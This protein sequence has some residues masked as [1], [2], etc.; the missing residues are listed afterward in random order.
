MINSAIRL[1]RGHPGLAA[2]VG[3]G[4]VALVVVV[5]V[6]FARLP[7]AA[8]ES[9]SPAGSTSASP[10]DGSAA[11]SSDATVE[12][13]PVPTVRPSV[14]PDW[15]PTFPIRAAFYYPWFPE[16][17]A[18]QGLD[19][20][21]KYHPS[22]GFYD[23]AA[24]AVIDSHIDAMLY[25]KISAGIASWWGQGSDTDTRMPALLA[26]TGSLPFRWAV[27]YEPEG[28]GDP[29]VQQIRSDLAYLAAHYGSDPAYLKVDGRMVVF[30][31]ADPKDGCAMSDRW[32]AANTVH[33]YVVLK[34][35]AGYQDCRRQP[36]SWH[37]Y[38]AGTSDDPQVAY[39]YTISP[40]F[41]KASE[42]I[43]RL[44]RDLLRWTSSIKT[45]AGSGLP[46]Q[47]ITTFNEWGE[48][49]SIESAVEWQTGSGYGAYLDALHTDGAS[50]PQATPIP[51]L[52][53]IGVPAGSAVLVGA[54]DIAS[55]VSAGDEQTA[56][57]VA[58]ISGTVIPLGDNAYEEGSL[59]QYQNCY[60][61]NWGG[62]KA[63]TMPVPGNHD[64]L[65]AGAQ[66][67]RDYFGSGTA[68]TYYAYDAG[69]WRVYALDSNCRQVGGCGPGSAQYTW[70]AA[71][72]AAHP[73]A[74]VLAYWHHPKFTIGP[75]ANDEGG[76]GVFWD[77]LQAHGAELVINGHEHSYER[78]TPM[79]SDGTADPNGIRLIVNGAGGRNVTT[80]TRSDARVEVE[81]HDTFGVLRLVLRPGGYDWQFIPIEGGTFGDWGSGSCH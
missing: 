29:S 55:C 19:P 40:G 56:A 69:T 3:V 51:T 28:Q 35:F 81:N 27:Y 68:V 77:L 76:S 71:D 44:E 62:F 4:L 42:P 24:A 52:Q 39:S 33:A 30:A 60:A 45:M 38:A 67:F 8:N 23:S 25:G 63:R 18:Q 36:D 53:P 1:V 6:A 61:G 21:T 11:P 16:A 65:T 58:G 26:A 80:P 12:P 34:V 49:S 31:Y 75:R 37:Q 41:N 5:A 66:G 48:G 20:F 50:G 32:A 17:W 46:W 10:G 54:G 43:V 73:R 64:Y 79:R 78:W 47:L 57:L 13:T 22:L 74:C 14:G 72:L 70:L 2:A 7:G 15:Q 9:P 59:Q